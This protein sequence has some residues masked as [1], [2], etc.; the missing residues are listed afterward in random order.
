MA[1]WHFDLWLIP[2]DQTLPLATLK[3]FRAPPLPRESL[4]IAKDRLNAALPPMRPLASRWTI[5][6]D[7]DASMIELY[8]EESHTEVWARIDARQDSDRFC[9]VLCDLAGALACQLY[10]AEADQVIEPR[11]RHLHMA[12]MQSSAWTFAL[13]PVA[14]LDGRR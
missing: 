8:A 12:L 9:M 4:T 5:Y 11:R 3:D 14:Y 2:I 6:G 13:D 10:L 7:P 1:A